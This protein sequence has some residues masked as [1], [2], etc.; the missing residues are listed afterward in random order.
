MMVVYRACHFYAKM[1]VDKLIEVVKEGEKLIFAKKLTGTLATFCLF[2]GKIWKPVFPGFQW[3]KLLTLKMDRLSDSA[4]IRVDGEL[5][6]KPVG[7]KKKKNLFFLI[8]GD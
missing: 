1:L 3:D 2:Q 7:K 6:I 8:G 5:A 4:Q